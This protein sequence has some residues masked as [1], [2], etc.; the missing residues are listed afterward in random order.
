MVSRE[1]VTRFSELQVALIIA[2][3]IFG[4]AGLHYSLG[5]SPQEKRNPNCS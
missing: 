1:L 4:L 2:G 3:F 5:R